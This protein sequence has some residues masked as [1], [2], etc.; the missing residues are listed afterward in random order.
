M[1]EGLQ[2]HNDV[3][4]VSPATHDPDGHALEP[5]L[6]PAVRSMIV[7]AP[8]SFNGGAMVTPSLPG[9]FDYQTTAGEIAYA[10]RSRCATC[11]HFNAPRWRQ[12][13][14]ELEWSADME[15]RSFVN[16]VRASIEQTMPAREREK[17]VDEANE[18]E[19]ELALDA[20]GLCEAMTEIYSREHAALFPALQL[21][22]GGC[23]QT[24][25]PHGTDLS[26]LYQ[27][28]DRGADRAASGAFDK[29][30]GMARGRTP[31]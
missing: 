22:T 11:K 20:F 10:M 23:P 27:P 24:K 15:K 31:G 21:P 30:M 17:F 25:T 6:A 8:L 18:L 12:L 19:I 7:S 26:N 3:I 14:R 2:I 29:I 28:R 13:R 5:E 16:E 9:S 4:K 1:S